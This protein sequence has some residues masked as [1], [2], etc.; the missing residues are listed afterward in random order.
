VLKTSY[1]VVNNIY[2]NT[3]RLFSQKQVRK[4]TSNFIIFENKGLKVDMFF[5]IPYG[6]EHHGIGSRTINKQSDF[7]PLGQR[8]F[9][10]QFYYGRVTFHN[11]RRVDRTLQPFHD[12]FTLFWRTSPLAETIWRGSP[13]VGV[14]SIF[15]ETF[16]KVAHPLVRFKMDINRKKNK[17]GLAIF[18]CLFINKKSPL[19]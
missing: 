1:T 19:L 11:I 17:K 3:F 10:D 16:G 7:V 15:L 5:G 4:F 8:A 14:A 6:F 9:G 13:A 18:I 12:G 2:L